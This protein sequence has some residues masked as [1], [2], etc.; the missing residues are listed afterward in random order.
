VRSHVLFALP[1]VVANCPVLLGRS[2]LKLPLTV[3]HVVSNCPVFIKRVHVHS[4]HLVLGHCISKLSGENHMLTTFQMSEVKKEATRNW[5]RLEPLRRQYKNDEV[6]YMKET[7][8]QAQRL[9]ISCEPYE[10]RLAESMG[11]GKIMAK[12]GREPVSVRPPA[13]VAATVVAATAERIIVANAPLTSTEV[14]AMAKA[15]MSTNHGVDYISAVKEV[16]RMALAAPIQQHMS[17][18]SDGVNRA[19]LDASAKAY[20]AAHPGIDYVSAI[21]AVHRS[22][23][24]ALQMTSRP[25]NGVS[26]ADLDFSAKKYMAAHPGVSYVNAV[27][28]VQAIS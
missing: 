12:R 15:H 8:A 13:A 19:D 21:K 24:P 6:A 27:K 22:A 23:A 28:A 3:L 10:E 20:M 17:I 4:F 2:G 7:T 1:L 18:A 9:A 25:N 11:L 16:R 5:R 26:R 14:D